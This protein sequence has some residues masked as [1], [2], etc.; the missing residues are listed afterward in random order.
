MT[1]TYSILKLIF[2]VTLCSVQQTL[3]D[4]VPTSWYGPKNFTGELTF[5]GTGGSL[6]A[7]CGFGNGP[8]AWQVSNLKT[9]AIG[10]GTFLGSAGC[11]IC[12][13]ITPTGTGS[14]NSDFPTRHTFLAFADNL[15]PEC[16]P[17]AVDLAES[18][19]GRWGI[20][21][22]VV[23]CPLDPGN[24]NLQLFIKEG[25]S[26]YHIEIN[27]RNSPIAIKALRFK[28]DGNWQN[29]ERKAYNYFVR[30]GNGQPVS[31]PLEVELESIFGETVHY[32]LASIDSQA[33]VRTD[34]QF[35]SGFE[36]QSGGASARKFGS[37]DLLIW[38]LPFVA[39]F[40]FW[41]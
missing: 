26:T 35:S 24:R 10:P 15:C 18:G 3:T 31:L 37:G 8:M 17:T 20:T 6:T 4:T 11:G 23:P 27:V 40:Y 2:L 41:I 5:Y 14:G 39:L 32:S 13:Q 22:R 34:V 29:V 12:L 28:I 33:L 25:S 38:I 19:D 36:P 30:D 1:L 16:A 9:I 21:Y 7:T